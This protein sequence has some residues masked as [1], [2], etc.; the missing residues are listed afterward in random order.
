MKKKIKRVLKSFM[1]LQKFLKDSFKAKAAVA[2][3]LLKVKM[4]F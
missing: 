2:T 4:F 1:E 3:E